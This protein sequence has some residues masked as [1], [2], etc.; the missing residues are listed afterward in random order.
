MGRWNRRIA[1]VR[2]DLFVGGSPNEVDAR[3]RVP[4]HLVVAKHVLTGIWIWQGLLQQ[5]LPLRIVHCPAGTPRLP[6]S[7]ASDFAGIGA[8][9]GTVVGLASDFGHGVVAPDEL[10]PEAN[11]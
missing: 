5:S 8:A 1:V 6:V 10:T 4:D 9:A 11:P 3:E 2:T 7:T